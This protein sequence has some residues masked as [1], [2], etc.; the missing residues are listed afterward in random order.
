MSTQENT[1]RFFE[2]DDLIWSTPFKPNEKLVLHALNSFVGA[3]GRCF[4]KQQRLAEMTGFNRSTVN[5]ILQRLEEQGA[6]AIEWR[7]RE[8]GSQTSN[9]Y[10]V[11]WDVIEILKNQ[12]V[13][14]DHTPVA[15]DHTPV[16][17][18]DTP[19]DQS[20]HQELT[21]STTQITTYL[22]DQDIYQS[23][24]KEKTDLLEKENQFSIGQAKEN[25]SIDG[26]VGSV[27]PEED[28]PRRGETHET[29]NKTGL[30]D[31]PWRPEEG[32]RVDDEGYAVLPPAPKY[33]WHNYIATR[34]VQLILLANNFY[35]DFA[36]ADSGDA[37]CL[38]R[39]KMSPE[40]GDEDIIL[41]SRGK[42]ALKA[43]RTVNEEVDFN[44]VIEECWD[45][46]CWLMNH[47]DAVKFLNENPLVRIKQIK[48]FLE[49]WGVELDPYDPEDWEEAV[50]G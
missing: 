44:D 12:G 19:C 16:T 26:L 3:D 22:T 50:F 8:D 45:I 29:Q 37:R 49:D 43:L 14:I 18:C 42:D 46:S 32:L 1:R 27:F 5:R 4:P 9:N 30:Y 23:F 20:A 2:R 33:K 28:H 47:R 11:D 17:E 21:N 40:G 38:V 24:S 36:I 25:N 6:I 13:L 35:D 41:S 31:M 48:E 15:N 34:L 39:T 7:H 10:Y